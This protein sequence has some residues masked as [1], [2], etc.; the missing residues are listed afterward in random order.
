MF[1]LVEKGGEIRPIHSKRDL[2][3]MLWAGWRK[4]VRGVEP[5]P[6]EQAPAVEEPPPVKRPYTK[7]HPKWRGKK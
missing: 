7:S 5:E 1:E 3:Y 4:A 6:V 2:E